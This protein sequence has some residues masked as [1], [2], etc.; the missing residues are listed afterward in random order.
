MSNIKVLG[1]GSPFGEDQAGW[2]ALEI[3]KS[4]LS[5]NAILSPYIQMECHDRPGS[6]LIELMRDANTVFLI[7]AVKSGQMPGII[8]RLQ[9][10]EIQECKNLISTHHMGVAQSLQLGNA[11]NELPN[12][13]ILYGIE[14]SHSDLQL[15]ISEPVKRGIN[16]VAVE[17]MHEIIDILTIMKIV[18]DSTALT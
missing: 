3:L 11:L 15:T 16:Q 12:N 5:L 4:R 17:L 1:I 6:N 13:I 8:H 2:K 14:I 18:H 9:N 7:D 10:D